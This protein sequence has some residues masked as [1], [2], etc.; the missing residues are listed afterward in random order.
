MTR[1]ARAPVDAALGGRDVER[2]HQHEPEGGLGRRAAPVQRDRGYDGGGQLVLDQ[3]VAD[4]GTVA[5]GEHDVDVVLEQVGDGL[6][7]HL[8]G[9][10]L[11]LDPRAAVLAGHRVAAQ[12]DQDPHAR[13]L[14]K[15]V[16]DGQG[17]GSVG[18]SSPNRGSARR[19]CQISPGLGFAGR[20]GSGAIR[21]SAVSQNASTACRTRRETE[22]ATPVCGA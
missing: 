11:V 7:R 4:L 19:Y 3:Q 17:V 8:A 14:A 15:R 18:S 20:S 9:G 22:P 13:N 2:L 21:P 5:V 6:H 16:R 12:G 1:A 10:D